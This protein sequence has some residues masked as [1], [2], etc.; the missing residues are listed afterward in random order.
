M[1]NRKPITRE[2]TPP[3]P[4]HPNKHSTKS[5]PAR[6]KS[7]APPPTKPRTTDKRMSDVL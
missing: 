4:H 1:L 6:G 5:L 2:L 7:L 3:P